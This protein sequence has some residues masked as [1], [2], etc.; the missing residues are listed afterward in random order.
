MEHLFCD[1]AFAEG[2]WGDGNIRQGK[3]I[4]SFLNYSLGSGDEEVLARLVAVFWTIWLWRNDAVWNNKVLDVVSARDQMHRFCLGWKEAYGTMKHPAH[5]AVMW[6]PP[7]RHTLKCNVDAASSTEGASFGAVVRNHAGDFVAARSG[8]IEGTVDPYMAEA[9]GVR[10][11]LSWLKEQ[12]HM[13]IIVESD[14]L[15]F[16]NAFNSS[17]FDLSY[18][19]LIVKQCLSIPRDIG[20][21]SITHVRRSANCVAHELA[22]ATGSTAVSGV[23]IDIPPACIARFFTQ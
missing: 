10:E 23:W 17:S 15:S 16:C 13:S 14:C 7:P 20:N 12:H 22:R 9:I 8:R 1:C 2:V 3:D 5:Q 4:V 19:G 11:T 18:V 6:K 21:V